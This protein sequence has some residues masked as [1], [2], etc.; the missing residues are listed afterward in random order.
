MPSGIEYLNYIGLAVGAVNPLA[1]D[2]TAMRRVSYITEWR[3][4][5]L[6][7][8]D[9]MYRSYDGIVNGQRYVNDDGDTD[10]LTGEPRIDEDFLDGRDNDG[11]G[12][13][14]EDFAALGQMMYT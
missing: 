2:P 8:E 13:I 1:T 3:P 5:T 7:P 14:D 12:K 4:P 10:P 11:D 9:R 6:D